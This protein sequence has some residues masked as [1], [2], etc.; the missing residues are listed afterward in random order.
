[1]K[2]KTFILYIIGTAVIALAAAAFYVAADSAAI[3][4]EKY[5]KEKQEHVLQYW[6]DPNF[7]GHKCQFGEWCTKSFYEFLKDRQNSK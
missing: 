2:I 7:Q 5:E 6:S 4:V 3:R 1:M